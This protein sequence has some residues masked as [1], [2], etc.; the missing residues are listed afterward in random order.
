[1][2]EPGLAAL[3]CSFCNKDQNDVRKLIA[4]PTVFICEECVEVC[5]DI[6]ADDDR[7]ESLNRA[8]PALPVPPETKKLLEDAAQQLHPVIAHKVPWM[9]DYPSAVFEA[10]KAVEAFVRNVS[11]LRDRRGPDLMRAAF[12]PHDGPLS[13]KAA[14]VEDREAI[15]HLMSGALGVFT[16]PG[17]Q[18]GFPFDAP[19]EAVEAVV[20]ASH[21][22]RFVDRSVKSNSQT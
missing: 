9:F 1:M 18:R 13:D 10:F 16:K 17:S 7:Y 6:I 14:P 21:L 8:R 4:G 12:D 5:T 20:F 2:N 19:V 3:R 22:L 15:M 11:G